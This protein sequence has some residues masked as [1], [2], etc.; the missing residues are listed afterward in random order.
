MLLVPGSET[1]V[2]RM[3]PVKQNLFQVVIIPPSKFRSCVSLRDKVISREP[4]F[5]VMASGSYHSRLLVCDAKMRKTS[6][7]RNLHTHGPIMQINC[8]PIWVIPWV[9]SSAVSVK[10]VAEDELHLLR[11][12]K[13]RRL[14]I[15]FSRS[16]QVYETPISRHLGNLGRCE[17][18]VM[19]HRT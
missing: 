15:H 6:E 2:S 1:D 18:V 9:E 7:R 8:L 11:R 19:L 17:L 14:C 5:V 3:P 13:I 4:L 16:F 12:V 10:L